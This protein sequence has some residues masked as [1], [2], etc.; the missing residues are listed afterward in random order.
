MKG[1]I[2]LKRK[3]ILKKIDMC[4]TKTIS[5]RVPESLH[6]RIE[7]IRV[8]ATASGLEFPLTDYLSSALSEAVHQAEEEI[9]AM[10]SLALAELDA[11]CLRDVNNSETS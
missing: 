4:K 9:K 10:T 6:R 8:A 5:I 1:E 2:E 7:A 11:A 3:S